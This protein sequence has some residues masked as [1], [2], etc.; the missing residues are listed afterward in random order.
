MTAPDI[1]P[2]H[3]DRWTGTAAQLAER[4]FLAVYPVGGW[5]KERPHLDRWDT[6]VR[7]AL[8]VAIETPVTDIDIYTPVATLVQ[9][10][11]AVPVTT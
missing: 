3:A 10:A 11:V 7:Y 2:H 1:Q 8:I 9:A 6:V 4:G 5:W